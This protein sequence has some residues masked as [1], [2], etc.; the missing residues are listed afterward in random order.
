[1]LWRLEHRGFSRNC[2]GS[3]PHCENDMRTNDP[4]QF[5]SSF[6]D[7]YMNTVMCIG[8]YR[9]GLDWCA[10]FD[11]LQVVTA[12]NYNITAD[13]HSTNHSTLITDHLQ[14]VTANN[15]NTTADVHTTNHSTLSLFSLFSQVLTMAV[16]LQ[17][18]D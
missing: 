4:Q 9:G 13:V 8:D 18:F 14:V 15:Y 5:N 2:E 3:S 7:E 6:P 11:H 1:M 12:N 17:C 10:D 16:L